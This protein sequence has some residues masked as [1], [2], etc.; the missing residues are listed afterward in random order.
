MNNLVI[1]ARLMT[2][3]LLCFV[4]TI[5]ACSAPTPTP[6]PMPTATE[7][8]RITP[9]PKPTATSA[10]PA[11]GE[12]IMR[13]N[14]STC[15]PLDRVVSSKKTRDQWDQTVIRMVRL[16]TTEQTILLDYLAANYKP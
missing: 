14:C 15:H 10:V 3:A 12:T 1:G 8:A 4:V 13:S 6:T 16:G 11:D 7:P 2:L 9:L 5:A